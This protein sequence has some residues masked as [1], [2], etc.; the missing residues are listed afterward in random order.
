MKIN[1]LRTPL[2]SDL[3]IKPNVFNYDALKLLYEE[4]MKKQFYQR[5]H[6]E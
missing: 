2:A 3:S 1:Q 6:K 5:N 4:A